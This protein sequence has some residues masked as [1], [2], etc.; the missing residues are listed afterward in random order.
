MNERENALKVWNH[1]VPEWVPMF[2]V[3]CQMIITP[4]IND[5]PLFKNGKDWFGLNWALGE[6]T[7]LMTH[8]VPDQHIL[9]DISEWR[10][11]VVFPSCKDLPWEQMA[12]TLPP[13]AMTSSMFET[14]FS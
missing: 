9:T 14:V 11:Q 8:V 12:M 4:E 1:E 5:R 3:C 10:K 13:R 2:N 7:A 6:N